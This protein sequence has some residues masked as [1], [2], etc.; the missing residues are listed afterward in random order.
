M[1]KIRLALAL[2]VMVLAL[3]CGDSPFEPTEPDH[4]VRTGTVRFITVEGGFWAITGDDRV[5][6]DPLSPLTAEFQREG[7][8][9]RFEGKV[10]F[11][12]GS[13]HMVGTIVEI[14]RIE[15]L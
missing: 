2:V 7:L 4:L 6:Y 15:K 13:T 12:V 11:D 14:I 5:T 1:R 3:A 9:V 10:R 8:R